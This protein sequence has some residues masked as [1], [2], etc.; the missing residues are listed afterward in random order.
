MKLI[1]A[2]LFAL[3]LA[4]CGGG[5]DDGPTVVLSSS[6]K[7]SFDTGP[8]DNNPRR[9]KVLPASIAATAGTPLDMSGTVTLTLSDGFVAWIGFS[10][11]G[12]PLGG[13]W[14]KVGAGTSTA[15]L[16]HVPTKSGP[17]E[18]AIMV[19]VG[20]EGANLI[21]GSAQIA[22]PAFIISTP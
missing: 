6:H 10:E 17:H 8:I 19:M 1:A 5:G 4:S 12:E 2:V 15:T 20:G 18:Y 21:H 16:R 13:Y 22:D 14:K 7:M 11:D 9:Y 3:A